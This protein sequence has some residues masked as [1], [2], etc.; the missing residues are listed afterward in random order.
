M[1][2]RASWAENRDASWLF[3]KLM[4]KLAPGD[5]FRALVL[6]SISDEVL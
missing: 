3:A 2:L 6:G 1:V 5:C 4:R